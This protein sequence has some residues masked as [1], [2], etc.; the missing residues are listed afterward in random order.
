MMRFAVCS[1][2]FCFLVLAY[3]CALARNMP[4][5][6][7]DD[8]S[9]RLVA[10][11]LA[12]GSSLAKE[13]GTD[14]RPALVLYEGS[15]DDFGLDIVSGTSKTTSPEGIVFDTYSTE[16]QL[17]KHVYANTLAIDL[18]VASAADLARELE[19]KT[20]FRLAD[21]PPRGCV[22]V[23]DEALRDDPDWPLDRSVGFPEGGTA[24]TLS[25]AVTLLET[26]GLQAYSMDFLVSEHGDLPIRD[27][28]VLTGD[29][30]VRDVLVCLLRTG[31]GVSGSE[32]ALQIKP[33]TSREEARQA[34]RERLEAR[35]TSF[36]VIL[37]P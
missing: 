22:I 4:E 5:V 2:S 21:S 37:I 24:L 17:V 25:E 32:K 18:S 11:H 6:H 8:V 13:F 36:S 1:V 31:L 29:A 27:G 10:K 26:Y 34:A 23:R 15:Q 20:D 14:G 7:V 30:T 35:K 16:A 33:V 3:P 19:A 12:D 9:A 28:N